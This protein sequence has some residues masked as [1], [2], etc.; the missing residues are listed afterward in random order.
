MRRRL[1]LARGRAALLLA[2]LLLTA[3]A[4]HAQA[5]QPLWTEASLYRDAWGVPYVQAENP[6]AMAFAFGYAQAED[7]L[8]PM[9]LA[10]RAAA[11]RAAEVLGPAYADWDAFARR[12]GHLRIARDALDQADPLTRALCEGFA[13]GVNAWLSAHAE[14]APAWAE[15]VEPAEVLALW[16]A[17]LLLQAP[18]DLPGAYRPP[19]PIESGHAWALSAERGSR[20]VPLLALAAHHHFEGPFRWYEAGLAVGDYGVH[21]LTFCGLPVIVQGVGTQHAWALTPHQADTADMEALRNVG[22]QR[23]PGDPTLPGPLEQQAVALELMANAE[24]YFVR[25]DNGFEERF[26]PVLIEPAGPVFE[27]RGG[28]LYIWRAAGYRRLGGLAQLFAMGAAPSLVAFDAALAQMQ[29][30]RFNVVYADRTNIAFRYLAHTGARQF[31]E[32]RFNAADAARARQTNWRQPVERWLAQA[33][34]EQVVPLAQMPALTN[35]PAGFVQASGGPPWHATAAPPFGEDDLPAWFSADPDHPRSRRV[36]NLLRSGARTLNDMQAM[37]FD[38][39]VP[40]A[41]AARARLLAVAEARP[42][43]VRAAHPDLAACLDLLRAW[44]GVADVDSA[45]MTFF[46]LWWAALRAQAGRAFANDVALAAAL[47]EDERLAGPALEAAAA[48]ARML[49]NEYDRVEVPWGEVHRLPRGDAMRPVGGAVT[50]S[51][52]FTMSDHVWDAGGWRVT[53]GQSH[54]L[55]VELTDPPQVVSVATF[56]SSE[57]PDSPHFDDQFALLREQRFKYPLLGRETVLR[58][59]RRAFGR[60]VQLRPPGVPGRVLFEA[61]APV[62]VRAPVRWTPPAA[63][64]EDVAAFSGFVAPASRPADRAVSGRV[65]IEVPAAVCPHGRQGPLALF[66]WQPGLGWRVAPDA[67]RTGP[68]QYTAALLP[69]AHY[70]VLGPAALRAEVAR[71]EGEVEG[72]GEGALLPRQLPDAPAPPLPV[73]PPEYVAGAPPEPLPAAPPEAREAAVGVGARPPSGIVDRSDGERIFRIEF[74]DAG[75]TKDRTED[76]APAPAAPSPPAAEG[77]RKFKFERHD[78]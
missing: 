51:P 48:A 13:L 77:G 49:R 46:H 66:A 20:G 78:E 24:P 43:Q 15:G 59:A 47:Q 27:G 16:H 33:A 29:L 21:G 10:Y 70:A 26:V 25:T 37:L 76:A 9:L 32:P 5:A 41:V 22:P 11:G 65:V 52:L 67:Q 12:A 72:E 28:N 73:P 40:G 31:P 4:A 57:R 53:Y 64:P 55:A 34:W 3:G 74:H 68:G 19:A 6:R 62:S 39:V 63:M 45:G 8:E 60:R 35:P 75:E 56:G 36:R 58:E 1:S 17:L 23:A 18:F 2:A 44:D 50:G 61:D 69:D 14:R 38:A 71:G 54:A 30:P 42:Q 7:H